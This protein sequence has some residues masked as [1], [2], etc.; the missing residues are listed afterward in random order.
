M[1]AAV[2]NSNNI[3]AFMTAWREIVVFTLVPFPVSTYMKST[4]QWSTD[5]LACAAFHASLCSSEHE[6]LYENAPKY[7]LAWAGKRRASRRLGS[8]LILRVNF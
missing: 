1:I 8:I 4:F 6:D 7:Q 3:A 2:T 5:A